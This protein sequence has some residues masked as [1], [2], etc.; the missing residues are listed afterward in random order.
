MLEKAH[1]NKTLVEEPV[2][3]GAEAPVRLLADLLEA[4]PLASQ[5]G[6]PRGTARMCSPDASVHPTTGEDRR[7]PATEGLGMDLLAGLLQILLFKKYTSL[8]KI[9]YFY[10]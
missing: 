10:F 3:A 9:S 8:S 1:S 2:G 5:P 7:Y 4:D 6:S